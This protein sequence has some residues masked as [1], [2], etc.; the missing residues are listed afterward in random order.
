[1]LYK[2]QN[3]WTKEQ[4]KEAIRKF[5]K[6]RRSSA[7]D[8]AG[9]LYFSPDDNRC[10]V[11]CFLPE[12]CQDEVARNHNNN[13]VADVVALRSGD[14]RCL[15]DALPLDIEGLVAI[16]RKHDRCADSEDVREVL[17]NWI[18]NFVVES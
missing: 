5:N 16:Q 14:G 18:D 17:C 1:M 10:G 2:V 4:M 11:G 15:R 6:G 13:H 8:G 7:D 3:G 12:W 9:C